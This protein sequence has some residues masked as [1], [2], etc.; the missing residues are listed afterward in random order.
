[1]AVHGNFP[2]WTYWLTSNQQE[3]RHVL[4]PA[5]LLSVPNFEPQYTYRALI[6]DKICLENYGT[7]CAHNDSLNRFLEKNRDIVNVEE[8][9]NNSELVIF[10]KDQSRLFLY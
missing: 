2:E 8:F 7:R 10:K 9:D 3:F 4:F 6:V 1:F 5:V